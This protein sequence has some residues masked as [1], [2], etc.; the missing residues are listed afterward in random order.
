MPLKAGSL[1]GTG[2]ADSMASAMETAF[3]NEWPTLMGD[4][5]L[6][7][8]NDQM[9]LMFVAIAQGVINHLQ[10]HCDA[11]DIKITN[12]NA[13]GDTGNVTGISTI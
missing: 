9:K 2:Y 10:L 13:V 4:S 11:F 6:P 5:P 1:S 3:N 12:G 7:A 8:S